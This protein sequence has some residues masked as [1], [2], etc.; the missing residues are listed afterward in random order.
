[1]EVIIIP[2]IKDRA[3]FHTS[4][5]NPDDPNLTPY[6]GDAELTLAG[7]CLAAT[8]AT[9]NKNQYLKLQN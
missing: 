5:I 3:C 7:F 4:G 9:L 2:I 6:T 8:T 1:M